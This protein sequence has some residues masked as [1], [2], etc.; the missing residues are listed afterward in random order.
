M[1]NLLKHNANPRVTIT[2]YKIK[3]ASIRNNIEDCE[4]L[5][6]MDQYHTRMPDSSVEC[7]ILKRVK[8]LSYISAALRVAKDVYHNPV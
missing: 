5:M 7:L 1:G 2:E 4:E 6:K 3:L 8:N